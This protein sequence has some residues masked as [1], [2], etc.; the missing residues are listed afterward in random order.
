MQVARSIAASCGL[1]HSNVSARHYGAAVSIPLA[2]RYRRHVHRTCGTSYLGDANEP[3]ASDVLHVSGMLGEIYRTANDQDGAAPPR[4]WAEA[5]E[6][7]QA[8]RH[9][10]GLGLVRPEFAPALIEQSIS[11]FLEP[12]DEVRGPE[13]LRLAFFLRCRLPRW[14]GPIADLHEH[15]VLPLYSPAAIRATF[16]MG[17][18]ARAQDRVHRYLVERRSRAL[19]EH[20]LVNQG[21]RGDCAPPTAPVVGAANVRRLGHAGQDDRRRVLLELLAESAANPLF[22]FVDPVRLRA[23]VEHPDRSRRDDDARVMGAM[24]ALIWLGR[25]ERRRRVGHD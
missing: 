16:R 2:E 19:A 1:T 24:A 18:D 25:M 7:F 9:R 4:S 22:E 21:W 20:P 5:A 15:R 6:R 11:R 3:M 10:D 23:A 14:Q 13:A 17:H 8:E 12:H